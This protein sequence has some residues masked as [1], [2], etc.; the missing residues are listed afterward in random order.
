[1][2][3]LINIKVIQKDFNGEKKRFVNARELHRWLGVGKRFATWITDRIKKYDFVEDLDYFTSIPI[4]GNGKLVL[5]KGKA[6]DPK[7]GRVVTK[8]YIISVDMAKEL[9]MIEN[10]EIGKKVRKYFIR[11]ESDFK[12]VMQIATRDPKFINMTKNSAES[13]IQN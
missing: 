6:K 2:N 10:S 13:N 9:A 7:T 12:K 1:M 5:N 11:V 3:E 8:D 4:S